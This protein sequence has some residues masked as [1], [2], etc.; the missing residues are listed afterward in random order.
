MASAF[1]PMSK[2]SV[3]SEEHRGTHAADSAVAIDDRVHAQLLAAQHSLPAQNNLPVDGEPRVQQDEELS[4]L[5]RFC[6][7]VTWCC[8]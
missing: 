6:T 5:E 1:D 2:T 8:E 4:A 7:D 3:N